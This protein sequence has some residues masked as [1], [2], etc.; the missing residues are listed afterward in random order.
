M[1]MDQWQPFYYDQLSLLIIEKMRYGVTII[2]SLLLCECHREIINHCILLFNGNFHK[3]FLDDYRN[4]WF[5]RTLS[6]IIRLSKIR[7][8]IREKIIMQYFTVRVTLY[9][10]NKI[11]VTIKLQR[12][13]KIR[14]KSSSFLEEVNQ[15]LY[16]LLRV[17]LNSLLVF[18][19]L[20]PHS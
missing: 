18:E 14:K 10:I 4:E 9:K 7:K 13:I 17:S 6:T 12:Q 8:S 16:K 19:Q 20:S 15:N 3:H 2:M 1:N 5:K 11:K